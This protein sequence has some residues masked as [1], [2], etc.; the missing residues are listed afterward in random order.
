MMEEDFEI[1]QEA[2]DKQ[3]FKS[4][5]PSE[6]EKLPFKYLE[7]DERILAIK[8]IEQDE[9]SQK[10]QEG[11][12][13]LLARYRPYMKD[14]DATTVEENLENNLNIIKT[15]DE[16]LQ[17]LNDP[18]RFRI[19]MNYKIGDKTFRLKLKI[20]QIPDSDYINLLDTQT[21]IFKD[22]TDSE[23]RVYAKASQGIQLSPEE[24]K[25]QKHIQDIIN[26]KTMDFN[27]NAK[28]I[29]EIL[30]KIV[31]FVDD[32]D[33]EF[34][35]KLQFWKQIDLPTRILLFQK[36]QDKLNIG[37]K[38]LDELFPPVG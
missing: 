19:D 38:S 15:S 2:V 10:E 23:K 9:L 31:D 12:K 17:L 27:G 29:T 28:D 32:P 13:E 3:L 25:M 24:S 33:K 36:I 35:E 8:C 18:N 11:V 6:C 22:L 7:E 26:E 30:A 5:Y 21:K 14:Y 16:L 1:D 34:N 4:K 37:D 20:K